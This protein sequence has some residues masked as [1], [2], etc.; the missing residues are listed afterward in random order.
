MRQVGV[1]IAL[2]SILPF[3]GTYTRE[4]KK[5]RTTPYRIIYLV[6]KTEGSHS[7]THIS[8]ERETKHFLLLRNLLSRME[9]EATL[10]G[11]IFHAET[12]LDE[13]NI[14]NSPCW[15]TK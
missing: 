10:R 11:S 12:R 4:K 1:K 5:E 2:S 3:F 13:K 7:H 8:N 15:M 6:S 9:R 14:G